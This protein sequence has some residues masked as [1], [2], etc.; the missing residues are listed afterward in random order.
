MKSVLAWLNDALAAKD[1]GAA[2]TYYR[3]ANDTISATDGRITA[4]HPWTF[5][6]AE[7]LVPGVEFEKI[8][9]R[10]KATPNIEVAK[11]GELKIRAGRLSG[12]IQTLP[13]TNWSYA[14]VDDVKW[15]KIPTSLLPLLKALRPFLSDNNT[16]AWSQCIALD[17]GWAYA[18]NNMAIAGAQCPELGKIKA[19]LPQWTLDF[20]LDRKDGL[21]DWVWSDNFVAFHWASGAWMRSQLIIGQFPEKAASMVRESVA[22][23]PTQKIDDEMRVAFG[24]IAELAEDT[25]MVYADRI[26]SKF[27]KA[28]VEEG[29]KCEIPEG[30]ECSI[31]GA[32]SLLPALNAADAWSPSVWPKPAPFKGPL[33]SGYVVGRRQ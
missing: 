26:E 17:D 27:G 19:L 31:W 20:I 2:M 18:T 1:I 30:E 16:Q 24:N 13:L 11:D 29:L 10:M 22:E 3:V 6:K 14:G 23:K 28:V 32:K 15:E 4:S 5:G 33:V 8:L 25:L 9:Q 12:T 7:F 21:T